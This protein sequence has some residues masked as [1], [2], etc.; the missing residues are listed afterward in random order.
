MSAK[1]TV[2]P[3]NGHIIV[4][5]KIKL[6]QS[7]SEIDLK[8]QKDEVDALSWIDRENVKKIFNY[9]PSKIDCI[10]TNLEEHPEQKSFIN[11]DQ[12]YPTY[13]NKK[14][15]GISKAHTYALKFLFSDILD[16]EKDYE[17]Y[18]HP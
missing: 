16:V 6:G 12:F 11:L 5:Y 4:F 13:P 14:W 15:T 3:S 9:Q 17:D 7:C 18:T 10:Y 8:L 2:A 1:G